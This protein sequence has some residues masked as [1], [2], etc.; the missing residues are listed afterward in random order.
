[1]K[2]QDSEQLLGTRVVKEWGIEKEFSG[3]FNK[4]R[5]GIQTHFNF[6]FN[7]IGNLPHQLI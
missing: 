2:K 6:G 5:N 7:N 1:M 3:S 4:I